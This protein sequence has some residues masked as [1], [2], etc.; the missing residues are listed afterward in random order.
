MTIL[1][2]PVHPLLQLNILLKV[3]EGHEPVLVDNVIM[4]AAQTLGV[5]RRHEAGV[6]DKVHEQLDTRPAIVCE[7]V[8]GAL[9]VEALNL[10]ARRTKG[11][12]VIFAH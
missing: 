11:V 12:D 3:Q 8:V 1:V 6:R 7:R 5:T 2:I 10:L 4:Q 9:G